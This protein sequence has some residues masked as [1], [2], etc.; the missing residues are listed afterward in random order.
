MTNQPTDQPT[1]Q[2]TDEQKGLQWSYSS[3]DNG[4][5]SVIH[6]SGVCMLHYA[7]LMDV[8]VSLFYIPLCL[9]LMEQGREDMLEV[10][11]REG[12]DEADR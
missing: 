7:S 11:G 9:M 4:Y 1:N 8:F 3:N 6:I 5:A 2:P 10:D 12:K